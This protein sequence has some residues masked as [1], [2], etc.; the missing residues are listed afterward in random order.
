MSVEP[1]NEDLRELEF[2]KQRALEYRPSDPLVENYHRASIE[3]AWDAL[4]PAPEPQATDLLR[5]EVRGVETLSNHMASKVSAAVQ[6]AVVRM[7]RS[8]KNPRSVNSVI[9]PEDRLRTEVVQDGAQGNVMFFRVPSPVTSTSAPGLDLGLIPGR[10]STALRELI[11]ILPENA[12]DLRSFVE[13]IDQAAPLKRVAVQNISEAAKL[14]EQGIS[15]DLITSGGSIRSVLDRDSAEALDDFLKDRET[16][17]DTTTVSG[18]LDG[19]R[20]TR[21]VFYLITNSGKEIAGSVEP[22]MLP[23]VRHLAGRMVTAQL[24]TT[25][26]RSHTGRLGPKAYGLISIDLE[27]E[28]PQL[29]EE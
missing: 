13:E 17:E 18:L 11:T 3:I 12:A 26:W 4:V 1:Y 14:S 10:A 6:N 27:A 23:R 16:I 5:V 29:F 28:T 24:S 7:D 15:L 20:G 8:L 2:L 22:D 25:Q 19:F 21:R 9:R